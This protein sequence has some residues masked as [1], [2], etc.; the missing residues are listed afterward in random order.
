MR[1]KVDFELDKLHYDGLMMQD[2]QPMMLAL[3]GKRVNADG[4]GVFP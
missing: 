1:L 4:N 2:R 3:W